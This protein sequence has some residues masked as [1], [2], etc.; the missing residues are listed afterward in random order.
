MQLIKETKLA[1]G[2]TLS[3]S[4]CCKLVAADRW[5]VKMQGEMILPLADVAW[6]D[7][8]NEDPQLLAR[9]KERLGESISYILSKERNFI[10]ATEKD[11]VLAD[12]VSQVENNLLGYLSDPSFPQK[13]F[14]QRYE[15]M[16]QQCLIE[17]QQPQAPVGDEDDAPADFSACFRD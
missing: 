5:L 3:F 1:N 14:L 16:R 4:D 12:L 7:A 13:L 15:E 9:I 2:L 8:D 11:A 10:G 6:S 17:G